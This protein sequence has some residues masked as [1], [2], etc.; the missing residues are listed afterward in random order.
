MK[1]LLDTSA[2]SQIVRENP[3][4]IKRISGLG[5]SDQVF[6]STVVRGELLYGI[7]RLPRGTKRELLEKKVNAILS[8]ILCDHLAPPVAEEYATLKVAQQN[9]GLSLDEND[10]WIA[11]SARFHRATLV[12]QDRD[13]SAI[14]G[15]QIEDWTV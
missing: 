6:V 11:A 2:I 12:T 5:G 14:E 9:K 4:F 7:N 3:I 10:L 13:F 15:L 1:Y 8:N